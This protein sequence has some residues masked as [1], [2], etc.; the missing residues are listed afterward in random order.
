MNLS[1]I[2]KNLKLFFSVFTLLF[3]VAYFSSSFNY[4]AP[5]YTKASTH[6]SIEEFVTQAGASVVSVS[7]HLYKITGLDY[8]VF[9]I[10]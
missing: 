1:A 8:F 7:Q 6:S 9:D 5:R 4:Y 10:T 2:R 3:A